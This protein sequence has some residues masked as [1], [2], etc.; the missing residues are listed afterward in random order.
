MNCPSRT[1]PEV[2]DSYNQNPDALNA[3]ATT[4]ADL[5]RIASAR[6][7]RDHRIDPGDGHTAEIEPSEPHISEGDSTGKLKAILGQRNIGTRNRKR[8]N[9][10]TGPNSSSLG[11]TVGRLDN[12]GCLPVRTPFRKAVQILRKY[13]KFIGPGFMV[14]V[15]YID[16]GK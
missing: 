9:S 10:I 15:A 14:A 2:P 7:Q 11:G 8:L 13:A 16:P 4:R 5:D 6:L 12:N 3:D 1:D